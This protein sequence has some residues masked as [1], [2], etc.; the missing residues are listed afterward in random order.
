MHGASSSSSNPSG[1]L[2]V[3][4]TGWHVPSDAEWTELVDYLK[5]QYAYICGSSVSN[6]A[7]SL[8]STTGWE[9]ATGNNCQVGVDPIDNNST[10][11]G[12]LPAGLYNGSYGDFGEFAYFWS[13]TQYNA[14]RAWFRYLKYDDPTV[15]RQYNGAAYNKSTAFSVRCLQD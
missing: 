6:V 8:A 4:P 15:R 10:G 7:K 13:T 3:C 5:T 11:L 9:T 14:S 12:M 1:V 2:G